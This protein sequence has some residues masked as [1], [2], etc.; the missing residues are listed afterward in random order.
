MFF[1][2]KNQQLLLNSL[3]NFDLSEA[4]DI[5]AIQAIQVM[6]HQIKNFI[7]YLT[8]NITTQYDGKNL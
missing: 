5:M 3:I 7:Q 4:F 2:K 1:T 6:Q 8:D